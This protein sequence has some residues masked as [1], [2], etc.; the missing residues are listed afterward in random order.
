M[1]LCLPKISSIKPTKS[2]QVESGT[3]KKLGDPIIKKQFVV[4]VQIVGVNV[5]L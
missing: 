4:F 2:S 1:L 5:K 3:F